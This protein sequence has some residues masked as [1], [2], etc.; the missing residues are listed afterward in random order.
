MSKQPRNRVWDQAGAQWRSYREPRARKPIGPVG[1]DADT[2]ALIR[3]QPVERKAVIGVDW[4]KPDFCI[5]V[6]GDSIVYPPAP[7]AEPAA[8]D[9]PEGWER[10]PPSPGEAQAWRHPA[11]DAQA[12]QLASGEWFCNAPGS[13]GGSAGGTR[14]EAMSAALDLA[15]VGA[16]REGWVEDGD[17]FRFD[18][19]VVFPL[20]GIKGWRW[21]GHKT[22]IG[23]HALLRAQLAV[24]AAHEE[25]GRG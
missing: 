22:F 12:W 11:T 21:Y 20:F 15:P 23:P 1:P 5:F 17:N 19:H 7:A 9:V 4:G 10:L 2:V 16:D 18:R 8:D 25:Q 3:A 14:N 13:I 24:E 6:S